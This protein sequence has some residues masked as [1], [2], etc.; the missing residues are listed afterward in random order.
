LARNSEREAKVFQVVALVFD[1]A[2]NSFDIARVSGSG[3][4]NALMLTVAEGGGEAG[5]GSVV[6]ELAEEFA[7]VIGLPSEVAELDAATGQ[8]RLNTGGEAS[9]ADLMAVSG[10]LGRSPAW[11]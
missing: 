8:M 2:V 6:L 11:A 4:R 7:D 1:E 9:A 5:T 3:G 10:T